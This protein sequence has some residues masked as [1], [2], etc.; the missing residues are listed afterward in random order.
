M[1]SIPETYLNL[2]G[3]DLGVMQNKKRVN[4]VEL[5]EWC[6]ENPYIFIY[7]MRKSLEEKLC[8]S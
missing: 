8:S 7:Y 1:Y 5:P 4:N 6:N 3:L 2:N